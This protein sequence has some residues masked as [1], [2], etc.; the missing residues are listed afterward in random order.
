[1]KHVRVTARVDPERAPPLFD[2]LANTPD[3]DRARVLD[4]NLTS[5]DAMLLFAVDGDPSPLTDS[6]PE[7]RGV[8]RCEVSGENEEGARV[9]VHVRR[10]AV[11]IFSCLASALDAGGLIVRTPVVFRDGEVHARIVGDPGP[12]QD[13]FERQGDDIEVRIDE[14]TS[15]PSVDDGSTNGLSDRQR[16]AVVA[17]KELGYYESPREA[18]HE[19]VAAVLGCSPQTAGDHLRKAEAKLVDAA[20]DEVGSGV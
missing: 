8:E 1:M 17:A 13:A 5:E 10:S 19:D 11:P 9:L 16:E 20:M 4:W 12:L 7:F 3:I 14:I 2:R 18:T 6:A 15:T